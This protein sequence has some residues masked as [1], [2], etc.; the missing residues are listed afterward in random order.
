MSHT[1]H[2][3]TYMHKKQV[4]G[5]NQQIKKPKKQTNKKPLTSTSIMI[6]KKSKDIKLLFT[7]R[8]N[9]MTMEL[10]SVFKI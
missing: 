5:K 4:N 2:T 6:S 1:V 7:H 3:N 10:K 8:F 9:V